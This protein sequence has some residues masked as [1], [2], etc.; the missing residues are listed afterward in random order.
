MESFIHADI[1]FF[2][3]TIAIVILS[4]ALVVILIYIIQIVRDVKEISA[5]VREEGDRILTDVG[6]LRE[7]LKAN[8]SK[9]SSLAKLIALFFLR[10]KRKRKASKKTEETNDQED[11]EN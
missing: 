8:G 9:F 11:I 1:F 4:L 7:S 2:V 5:K 6:E 10:G 3:T